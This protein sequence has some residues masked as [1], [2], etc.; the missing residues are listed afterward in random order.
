MPQYRH[1]DAPYDRDASTRILLSEIRDSLRS[2]HEDKSYSMDT[3]KYDHLDRWFAFVG[4]LVS[5]IAFLPFAV[6]ALGFWNLQNVRADFEDIRDQAD[7]AAQAFL[8]QSQ[9]QTQQI[10]ALKQL[11]EA[12]RKERVAVTKSSAH[13]I[14]G[15]ASLMEGQAALSFTNYTKA[16][17]SAE[18][19][20]TSLASAGVTMNPVCEANGTDEATRTKCEEW[21]KIFEEMT[22]KAYVLEA[23][24]AWR[25]E[26]PEA[27]IEAGKKLKE[28]DGGKRDGP[29]YVALGL[30]QSLPVLSEKY[31]VDS[32]RAQRHVQKI[33]RELEESVAVQERN[34]SDWLNLI[35]IHLFAGNFVSARSLFVD[36]E[37]NLALGEGQLATLTQCLTGVL[38][39]IENQEA[40]D[41]G[42]SADNIGSPRA[43]DF[44]WYSPDPAPIVDSTI[45]ACRQLWDVSGRATRLNEHALLAFAT[46]LRQGDYR[47]EIHVGPA[48][49]ALLCALDPAESRVSE[50]DVDQSPGLSMTQ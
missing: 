33:L 1:H 20:R 36:A 19:A 10:D 43:C 27:T 50:R 15:M 25:S 35:Q 13:L 26:S 41:V 44:L 21:T 24:A 30:M 22:Q 31:T 37:A 39:V 14:A 34:N 32:P 16:I 29:H 18:T 28:F 6:T 9:Q 11:N 46:R 45:G 23:Q 5:F 3:R 38:D 2:W 4:I 40:V 8:Q 48:R 42:D 7:Q 47:S 49:Q 17:A 12:Y